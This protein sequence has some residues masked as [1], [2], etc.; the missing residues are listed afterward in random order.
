MS[1]E[2]SDLDKQFGEYL[3]RFNEAVGDTDFG[4]FVK[5]DGKLVKKLRREEF[6]EVYGEYFELAKRYL[7][8]LD[9]GDTIND[10]VVRMLRQKAAELFLT[11]PI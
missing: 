10:G 11:P 6:D 4:Q 9:R 7:E 5:H 2:I 8:S 3:A 1:A